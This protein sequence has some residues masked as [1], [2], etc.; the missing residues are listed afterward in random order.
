MGAGFSWNTPSNFGC[1]NGAT[2]R[3]RSQRAAIYCR[4]DQ[5][6]MAVSDRPEKSKVFL[7]LTSVILPETGGRA[8]WFQQKAVL[9]VAAGGDENG[10]GVALMRDRE[11][12]SWRAG[13]NGRTGLGHAENTSTPQLVTTLVNAGVVAIACGC[14]HALAIGGDGNLFSWGK[15]SDGATGLG[16]TKKDTLVPTWVKALSAE[17]VVQINCGWCHSVAL[18]TGDRIFV[19]GCGDDGRLG[20]G[21]TRSRST[22]TL[23]QAMSGHRLRLPTELGS[24]AKATIVGTSMR[25]G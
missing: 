18:V 16:T 17:K 13:K 12:F 7:P 5:A 1:V 4:G 24:K 25:L 19:W 22:P 23:N 20:L 21:D 15:N 3:S 9:A 11:V 14:G 6:A 2:F 8:S 10:Y